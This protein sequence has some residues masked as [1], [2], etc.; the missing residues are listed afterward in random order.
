MLKQINATQI[1]K[2]WRT[3]GD[4]ALATT[5]VLNTKISWVENKISDVS[6]LLKKTDYDSKMKTSRKNTLLLLNIIDL[7]VKHF[8]Q[9]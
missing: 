4:I 6:G 3:N 7:R 2:T 5:T 8:I 9:S 1:N